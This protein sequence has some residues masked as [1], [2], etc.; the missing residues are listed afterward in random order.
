VVVDVVVEDV[1][2][3][4]GG[5]EVRAAVAVQVLEPDVGSHPVHE[6]G[7]AGHTPRCSV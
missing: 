1:L 7:G 2:A 5:G 3:G 4:G 6:L